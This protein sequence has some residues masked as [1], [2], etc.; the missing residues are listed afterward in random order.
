MAPY[1]AMYLKDIERT[2]D[3]GDS[4]SA[5]QYGVDPAQ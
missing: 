4:G 1:D 2:A 5:T 3:Q